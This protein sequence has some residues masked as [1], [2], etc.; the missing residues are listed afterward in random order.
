MKANL[1]DLQAA[2]G[3][4]QL[5]RLRAW[6]RRRAAIAARYDAQLGSVRGLGLPPRPAA[7]MHA[8]HLYIV[9]V[10]R[11]AFGMDRDTVSERL[12][13][14]ASARPCISSRFIICRTSATCSAGTRAVELPAADQIF[15]Q[16]LSLP[17]YPGADRFRRGPRVRGTGRSRGLNRLSRIGGKKGTRWR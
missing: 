9:R 14:P 7:D 5:H 11:R 6:Q 15:P 10:H 12:A 8:W 1:T 4:E 13:K 16:L 3:R 17:L 2:I